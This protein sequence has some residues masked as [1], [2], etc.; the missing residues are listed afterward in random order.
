MDPRIFNFDSFL[1][2]ERFSAVARHEM[3]REL[4]LGSSGIE[5]G[6]KL[7]LQPQQIPLLKKLAFSE[8]LPAS[9][10]AIQV[11]DLAIST[12]HLGCKLS[13]MLIVNPFVLKNAHSVFQDDAGDTIAIQ[14]PNPFKNQNISVGDQIHDIMILYPNGCRLTILEPVVHVFHDE[15]TGLSVTDFK[16][17]VFDGKSSL[18]EV[19]MKDVGNSLFKKGEFKNASVAYYQALSDLNEN[20]VTLC[21]I[22]TNISTTLSKMDHA[23]EAFVFALAASKISDTWHKG[24]Y[25]AAI[26]CESLKMMD[27]AHLFAFRAV[28]TFMAGTEK[29]V[30]EKYL[31]FASRLKNSRGG[32]ATNTKSTDEKIFLILSKTFNLVIPTML[33]KP[34][35]RS[36]STVTAEKQQNAGNQL[37]SKNKF[38]K[39]LKVYKIALYGCAHDSSVLLS[40]LSACCLGDGKA[41]EA[42]NLA[43]LATLM[44]PS[45]L[46]SH[47]RLIK[48]LMVLQNID[49][50]VR[51]LDRVI[52]MWPDDTTFKAMKKK[53]HVFE[54]D[55]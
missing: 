21:T 19:R 25:R 1:G 28:A 53:I 39:A 20:N 8:T 49:F 47:Q 43:F 23:E 38:D 9:L 37:Y 29:P 45:R 6:E 4:M 11:S 42:F 30:P 22:L 51:Y 46:K 16:D 14:L 40:K 44:Y 12:L 13:G 10:S 27:L 41:Y 54:E 32:G 2:N 26:T 18:E 36:E 7:H 50:A 34:S 17:V 35:N 55:N 24:W 3:N 31:S 33:P 48:S 5:I 15:V 52:A